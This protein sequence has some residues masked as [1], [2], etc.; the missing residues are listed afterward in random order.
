VFLPYR[1][2][3]T[4]NLFLKEINGFTYDHSERLGDAYE[5]LL[6]VLGTQG[7]AGQFRTPRHIIDFI[8]TVV[9][10]QKQDTVL[11]PACGTAGFL[12]SAY[13]HILKHNKNLT[14]DE[15]ARLMTNFCG[16]DIAPDM[17]RLS[18]VNLY[19]HGFPNPVIHEY[20]TLTSEERWDERYDVIMAN[21]PFMSP[22]AA[23]V[24]TT[25]FRSKPI[26]AK[27]YSWT[28]SPN[29]STQWTRRHHR[30]G[31]RRQNEPDRL[32][33][34]PTHA[35]GDYLW[36][37]VSLPAG[38]FNPYSDNKT[39]I[40]FLDR[41]LAQR[42]ESILFVKVEND[43]FDLGAQRRPIE[44]DDLPDALNALQAWRQTGK[45]TRASTMALPVTRK[46]LLESHDCSLL[47]DR[48]RA[49]A[50]P[51]N[52]KWPV[53]KL[54]G[55]CNFMTGGT[56]SSTNKSYYEGGDIPWLVSGDIHKEEI[57][58]CER[59]ITAKGM[60]IPMR[61]CCRRARYSLR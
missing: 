44:T 47:G 42:T 51:A 19:L 27:F 14:P 35:G 10:P 3:E 28:T 6:S 30:A 60:G 55:V 4:L 58:D 25:G 23:S 56:P 29:T 24:R 1:D 34:T 50:L 61:R 38:V 17:V 48:Y 49:S 54:E 57:T 12:I 8:A 7:D 21:P 22:K 53:V 36:A 39:S 33:A 32:P 13:K 26:A 52:G 31:W 59:R 11:D 20:D 2:P 16:Y 18:R 5:Y 41:A 45:F 37:V 40:L 46:R 15:R 9:D 43:G